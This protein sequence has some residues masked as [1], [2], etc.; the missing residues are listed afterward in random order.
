VQRSSV[1][2]R[3]AVESHAEKLRP[4]A[5]QSSLG[6][7]RDLQP[8]LAVLARRLGKDKTDLVIYDPYY[9]AGAV[10]VGRILCAL[11]IVRNG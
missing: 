3:L 10:E 7:G 1:G 4:S 11:T 9:C 5:P 6:V 8:I 2:F